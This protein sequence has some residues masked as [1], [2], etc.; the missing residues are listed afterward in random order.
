M[1]EGKILIVSN[2]TT[3]FEFLQK[4]FQNHIMIQQPADEKESVLKNIKENFFNV[5][6][7]DFV[8]LE[9]PELMVLET[10]STLNAYTKILVMT[11]HANQDQLFSAMKLGVFDVIEKPVSQ[12]FL[13]FVIHR[14]LHIQT[15]A[16]ERQHLLEELSHYKVDLSIKK[17]CM[18]NIKKNLLTTHNK[19]IK[20]EQNIEKYKEDA[21]SQI[22][23]KIRSLFLPI[24]EKLRAAKG[25]EIYESQFSVLVGYIEDLTSGLSQNLTIEASLSPCELKIASMVKHGMTSEEIASHLVISPATVRTHRRNIR[26]KLNIDGDR[27]SL[28]SHLKALEQ[29]LTATTPT[30]PSRARALQ[31]GMGCQV[32]Q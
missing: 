23:L 10:I 19:L 29:N 26:R 20:L 21:E 9:T 6:F 3:D 13:S 4:K 31:G 27:R 14:A 28:Q 22:I 7:L 12:H 17:S 11:D 15:I 16:F 25:M 8:T 18:R 5:V 30:G 1:C 24:V 32:T 2:N